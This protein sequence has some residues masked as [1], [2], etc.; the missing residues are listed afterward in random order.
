M[1]MAAHVARVRVQD[2]EYLTASQSWVKNP[3]QA[4]VF[5]SSREATR[6]AMRLPSG[7]RAFAL[8]FGQTL[9]NA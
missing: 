6:Q 1:A 8:P 3:S 7:L 9:G 2:L 5:E 4:A